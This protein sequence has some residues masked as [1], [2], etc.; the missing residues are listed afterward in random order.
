MGLLEASGRINPW[1]VRF[2]PSIRNLIDVVAFGL[3]NSP[4]KFSHPVIRKLWPEINL[5]DK[6][7]LW[8][9]GLW[10]W[11]DPQTAIRA[12][13]KIFHE[14]SNVKLVFPGTRHPNPMMANIPTHFEESQDLARKLGIL[15]KAV[16]LV[17]G[18]HMMIGQM[19]CLI[20]I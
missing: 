18:F 8:G 2:D 17:S 9:R 11:L 15:N 12:V 1:T 20:A 10:P 3:P 13:N 7:I 19:F 6:V 14:N 4:P 16:F 5:H